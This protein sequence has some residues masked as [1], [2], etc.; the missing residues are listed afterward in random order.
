MQVLRLGNHKLSALVLHN[1]AYALLWTTRYEEA[2]VVQK[3][4]SAMAELL[5]DDVSKVYAFTARVLVDNV[6]A[7]RE[8]N[9]F[10]LEIPTILA[11]AHRADDRYLAFGS[12]GY[13]GGTPFIEVSYLIVIPMHVNSWR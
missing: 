7:P 9:E 1:Y 8:A 4:L 10:E 12:I 11:A 5:D 6:L 13:W 2:S 3:K